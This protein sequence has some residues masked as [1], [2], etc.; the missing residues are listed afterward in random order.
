VEVVVHTDSVHLGLVFYFFYASLG[1]G[2]H[3]CTWGQSGVI[4]R[5]VPDLE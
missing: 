3:I 2:D 1:I 5:A 4:R